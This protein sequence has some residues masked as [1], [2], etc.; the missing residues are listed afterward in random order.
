MKQI[1]IIGDGAEQVAAAVIGK[2]QGVDFHALTPPQSV[3]P[4]VREQ[5]SPT[6][7]DGDP[8]LQMQPTA[9]PRKITGAGGSAAFFGWQPKNGEDPR[10]QG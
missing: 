9:Q 3:A 10:G 7:D 8:A 5:P 6:G 1:V 4:V 2:V